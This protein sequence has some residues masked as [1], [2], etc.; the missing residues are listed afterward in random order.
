MNQAEYQRIRRQLDE[1]LRAGIEMLQAGH[2][3][4]VAALDD[5]WQELEPEPAGSPAAPEP[6]SEPG[7]SAASTA[8]VAVPDER[9]RLGA[10][11]LLAD[12]EAALDAVGDEFLKSDL[13]RALGY[14]PHR[15]S[16]HRALR[17]LQEDGVITIHHQGLGRRPSLY[18]GNVSPEIWNIPPRGGNVPPDLWNIPPNWAAIAQLDGDVPL[19]FG[20][21]PLAD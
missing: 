10:G 7:L 12:V 15:S 11:E 18:R 19:E 4:K 6:R 2:R 3:A 20:T 1:E 14:E 16:L 17:E 13:C 5:R 9:E 8:P 21:F